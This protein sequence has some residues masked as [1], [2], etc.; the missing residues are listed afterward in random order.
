MLTLFVL[1]GVGTNKMGDLVEWVK[2]ASFVCL[3][4]LFKITT[5]EMNYQT[6]ISAQNLLAVVRETRPYV[7]NILPKQ[8][9]KVV[10]PGEHF[11]L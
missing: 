5:S 11:V 9:P 2:K 4:K 8:L 6:L 3:N 7:L 10:V 1:V